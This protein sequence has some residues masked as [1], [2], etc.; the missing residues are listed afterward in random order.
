MAR[1]LHDGVCND[2]LAIRMNINAGKPADSTAEMIDTCRESV[3][4][5]SHELM[6]PEFTYATIDEVLRYYV[7]QLDKA[8]DNCHCTYT[9]SADGA[10]WAAVPDHVALEIYRIV[11]EAA[12]NALKHASARHI[13]V[14][15]TATGHHIKLTVSDDGTARQAH[16]AGIGRR[17]MSGR[18]A[19]VGGR[20]TVES[21]N[22]GTVVVFTLKLFQ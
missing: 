3:R 15:M 4:R 19:A 22:G 11:Q 20:L 14:N 8:A 13:K 1:E 10:D 21:G 2:L 17:T 6:P 7:S 12:G 18:A 9:S 16:A 5:I